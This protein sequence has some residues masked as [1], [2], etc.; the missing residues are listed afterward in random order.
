MNKSQYCIRYKTKAGE[1]FWLNKSKKFSGPR[2]VGNVSWSTKYYKNFASAFKASGFW[3][4]AFDHGYL[5][6]KHQGGQIE[7]V[8]VK[9]HGDGTSSETVV[10]GPLTFGL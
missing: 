4:R 9:D 7:L 3:F 10:W 2:T 8:R 5:R 1:E 6:N